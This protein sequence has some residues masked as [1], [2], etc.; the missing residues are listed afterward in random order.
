MGDAL[1]LQPTYLFT[2]E[3]EKHFS[4]GKFRLLAHISGQLVCHLAAIVA[5]SSQATILPELISLCLSSCRAC[6]LSGSPAL[7]LANA[8]RDR[9]RS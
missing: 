2:G 1:S 8:I 5:S 9:K 7:R 6:L 4:P 3:L